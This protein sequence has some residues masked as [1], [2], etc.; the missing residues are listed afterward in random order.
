MKYFIDTEFIEGFHKP[1]FGRRRHFIDLISIGIVCEDGR[2]YYAVSSEY[3]EKDASEWVKENVIHA[4]F[5]EACEH[6]A[7]LRGF[8]KHFIKSLKQI[9]A[10][11][12]EFIHPDIDDFIYKLTRADA[13]CEQYYPNEFK[14][15]ANH[16]TFIPK[17]LYSSGLNSDGYGKNRKLIYNQPEFYGYYCDYDWVLLCS[18]FGTMM[19]LPKGFPMYCRD[20]KQ[21]LDEVVDEMHREKP[22]ISK[23]RCL[24]E[25]K[26]LDY[27]N[28][29]LSFPKQTN[30]HN[31]LADARWNKKLYE[32]LLTI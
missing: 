9:T 32:F 8:E 11:I 21:T 26:S 22:Q 7:G 10:D 2:E 4:I 20:L 25:L 30:E 6:P 17:A 15:I 1:L 31:A 16:N 14:Y 28:P 27:Q 23:E 19:D 12:V 18:L 29:K 24:E 3:N 13:W 5:K